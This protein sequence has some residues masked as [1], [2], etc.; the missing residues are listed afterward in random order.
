MHYIQRRQYII[1][2]QST[3]GNAEAHVHFPACQDNFTT[4]LPKITVLSRKDDFLS[5]VWRDLNVK[6]CRDIIQIKGDL[7]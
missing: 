2:E 5:M 3:L 1:W 7:T 4:E 6:E